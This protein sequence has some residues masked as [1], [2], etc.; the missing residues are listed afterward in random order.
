M[1]GRNQVRFG[2][3]AAHGSAGRSI[4]IGVANVPA[5]SK[6]VKPRLNVILSAVD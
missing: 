5:C 2:F 6:N 3:E 1:R 4:W